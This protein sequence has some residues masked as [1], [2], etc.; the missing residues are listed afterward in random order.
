M[1]AEWEDRLTVFDCLVLCRF[2]RDLYQW[3]KLSEMIR[4]VTGL[5]MDTASMRLL[6]KNVSDNAR[7]FNIREGL[8]PGDD[9]LPKHF[10]NH[11][12]PETNKIITEDQMARLLKEYYKARGWDE[13]GSPPAQ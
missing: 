1:F 6:A 9:R 3:E 2:Y 7:R 4:A 8:T 5:E 13:A 12:L 10:H 11:V